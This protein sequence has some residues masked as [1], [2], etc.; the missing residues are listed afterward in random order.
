M[1]SGLYQIFIVLLLLGGLS[2]ILAQPIT[3]NILLFAFPGGKSHCFIFLQLIK[4]TLTKIKNDHPHERYK[5]HILVHN[6]DINLWNKLDVDKE[7]FEI[8]GFGSIG[9]Y[10]KKFLAAMELA[11]EDPIF[12]YQ[13]FNKAMIFI[14][15]ELLESNLLTKFKS[16]PFTFDIIIT[17]VVNM[18]APFLKRELGI[19]KMMYVNPTCIYTWNMPNMEYNASYEPVIG[20]SFSDKMNFLQRMMNFGIKKGTEMMYGSFI[21][22]QNKAFIERGYEKLDPFQPRSL[23]LN[24]CVNGIHFP[25]SLPPNIIPAGAF[26]PKPAGQLTDNTLINFLNKYEKNI[27]VSQGT[28]T[29]A[30]KLDQL[31]EVFNSFPN[32]GFVFSIRKDMKLSSELP[33][34]V[35]GMS[36]VPQN[37]LLGDK[38][39]KAFLTHGGLNSILESIYHSQPM[40][41]IGTSI[42]QVN[43]AALVKA[44][45]FGISFMKEKEISKESLIKAIKEILSNPIYKSNVTEGSKIVKEQDGKEAFYYWLNYAIETGYDHLILP[46]VLSYSSF[47]LFNQDIILVLGIFILFGV[48]I[49]FFSVKKYLFR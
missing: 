41:V 10:D 42:D 40:I 1:K 6:Y 5:F 37:D 15:T 38:R 35:L 31:V 39:I 49:S 20:T 32:I 11:K 48:F 30:M 23:F 19:P 44:R 2:L 9:E 4:T 26:L 27:Y 12:G 29:K 47:E 21:S 25:L 45:N 34:N 33:Q 3:K 46:S 28:I 36:W 14:N 16:L 17:D 8:Y 18:V 13:N 22:S 7:E 43:S 24:Q